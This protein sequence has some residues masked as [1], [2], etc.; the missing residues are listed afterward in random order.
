MLVHGA[1]HGAWCWERLVAELDALGHRSITVDLPIE[2]PDASFETYADV[3]VDAMADED[4]EVV[5]VGHSMGGMT[6]PRVAARRP[7]GSLVYLCGLV[8]MPGHSLLEQ[9]GI[10]PDTLLPEYQGGIEA[11]ELGRSRWVDADLAR[12]VM[13]ADCEEEDAAA[14]FGR[15]RRQAGNHYALPCGLEALP[16]VRTT[17]VV[18]SEDRLVNPVWSRRVATGRLA[19][20]LVELPG[21]H[22]PFLSR[23]KDV[24]ELLHGLAG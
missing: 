1:W 22:S 5:L 2:D 21:S 10:E 20:D 17:Y 19:A 23:P 11:D 9:F 6:I 14:A 16:D 7:V 13:Y 4:E 24:A 3:V 8:P 18:C 15:L 12:R